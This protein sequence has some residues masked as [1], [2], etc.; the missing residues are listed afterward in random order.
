MHTV[1]KYKLNYLVLLSNDLFFK[2]DLREDVD[3][4]DDAEEL[5]KVASSSTLSSSYKSCLKSHQM[6][7]SKTMCIDIYP[8]SM[9]RKMTHTK[10]VKHLFCILR[11]FFFVF[12]I[13]FLDLWFDSH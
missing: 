4:A 12:N 13:V 5:I 7:M 3:V 1:T 10:L 2:Q 8:T 6:T 9:W 11:S